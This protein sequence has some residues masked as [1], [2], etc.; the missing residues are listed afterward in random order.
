MVLIVLGVLACENRHSSWQLHPL[1]TA[2]YTAGCFERVVCTS[3]LQ[4]V[5]QSL[6]KFFENSS[7]SRQSSFA[8]S[9]DLPWDSLLNLLFSAPL[10][11]VV[12]ILFAVIV[13]VLVVVIV[14][15]AVVMVTFVCAPCRVRLTGKPRRPPSSGF[16]R[17]YCREHVVIPRLPVAHKLAHTICTKLPNLHSV[18]SHESIIESLLVLAAMGSEHCCMRFTC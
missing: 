12:S 11:R 8:S 6:L 16:L 17:P 18:R 1:S 7:R 14:A 13:V 15:A 3:V 5:W 10:I 2:C 9:D 4:K